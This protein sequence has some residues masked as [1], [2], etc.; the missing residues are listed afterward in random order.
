METNLPD[1]ASALSTAFAHEEAG[2]RWSQDPDC[3][4]WRL[5]LDPP[6]DH[7]GAPLHT[8]L[9]LTGFE[10]PVQWGMVLRVYDS[11]AF[12]YWPVNAISKERRVWTPR[13]DMGQFGGEERHVSE[14]AEDPETASDEADVAEL[15][16]QEAWV[17]ARAANREARRPRRKAKG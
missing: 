13:P 11:G 15:L 16:V 9:G 14:F 17:W 7:L 4:G 8:W 6:N 10:H 2:L 5:D 3:E 12:S 1:I